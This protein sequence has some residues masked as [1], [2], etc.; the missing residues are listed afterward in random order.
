MGDWRETAESCQTGC[1]YLG[2]RTFRHNL[3]RDAIYNASAS[4]CLNPAREIRGLLPGSA[5][6]PAD[7]F[8]PAWD[9]GRDA[10]LDVTVISPLQKN[11]VDRCA[12]NH[13]LPLETAHQRKMANRFEGL[14]AQNVSLIPLAVETFGG[15]RGVKRA[16]FSKAF[17]S[18]SL[19]ITLLPL[20]SN[21]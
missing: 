2:E 15:C 20:Q 6:R 10:A 8:L 21:S 1:A 11:L 4:A 9:K 17:G 12:F 14:R 16:K 19:G 3:L 5:A 13:D 18:L 7:V